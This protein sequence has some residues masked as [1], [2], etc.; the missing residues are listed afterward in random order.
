MRHALTRA[1]DLVRALER[2]RRITRT[3]AQVAVLVVALAAMLTSA[4]ARA[5]QTDA[6]N[7]IFFRANALYG[8][9]RYAEAAA[10]YERILA[11]GLESGPLY[12]NL[13]NA[14]FKTGDI[15]RSVL[16][17]ERA[18]RLIPGDPDVHA[19][20]RFARPDGDDEPPLTRR[21]LFPLAT[22]VSTDTLLLWASGLYTGVVLLLAIARLAPSSARA[23]TRSAVAAGVV[24]AV[25]ATSAA[26]R[27]V[28]VDLPPQAVVVASEGA[29]VRF[30]P[31]PSGTAHFEVK[32]GSRLRVLATRD[33]WSQVARG[34]GTRGWIAVD[35]IT[36]L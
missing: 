7:T 19:N 31:S 15:G 22:G 27:L 20:L 12:F 26:Y 14:Y 3:P 34:D 35:A 28:S 10:E 8:E 11:S 36:P 21:L 5:A 17:Y 32:T 25:V 33:G 4:A 1:E 23:A 18:R 9:E 2:G 6:P 13:G 24:L 30:E 16:A 29:T